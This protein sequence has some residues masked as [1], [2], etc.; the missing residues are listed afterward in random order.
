MQR[1]PRRLPEAAY[2]PRCPTCGQK[3]TT[4]RGIKYDQESGVAGRGG[5]GRFAK[6][7]PIGSVIFQKLLSAN[8]RLVSREKLMD[9]IYGGKPD[10]D[11]P[12]TIC[13]LNV[14]I[15]AVRTSVRKLGLTVHGVREFGWRLQD[16]GTD[17][18]TAGS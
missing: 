6:F 4:L 13:A 18:V 17:Q 1:S 3:M 15:H 9:A 10:C 2:S 16:E 14:Q 7:T 8:G 12:E 11:I 5:Y